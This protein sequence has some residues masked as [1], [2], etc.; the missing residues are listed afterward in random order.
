MNAS[1]SVTPV[2]VNKIAANIVGALVTVLLCIGCIRFVRLLPHHAPAFAAWQVPVAGLSIM[3]VVVIHEM[4][5]GVGIV[6]FGHVPRQAI[7]FGFLWS[8]LMPYCHCTVPL[9]VRAYRR[10]LLLPLWVTG[11][12]AWLALLIAP[13]DWLALVTGMTCAACVGD[14]WIVLKLRRIS[15]DCFVKDSPS[16]I[17]CDVFPPVNDHLENAVSRTE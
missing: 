16:D 8:A 15:D 5:H 6:R 14:V 7:R 10:M 3:V 9:S 13:S 4:L 2:R 12:V 17:G 11:G 1:P